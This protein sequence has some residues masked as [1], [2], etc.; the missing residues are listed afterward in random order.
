MIGMRMMELP[1][2]DWRTIR[3][4]LYGY[5]AARQGFPDGTPVTIPVNTDDAREIG[6]LAN[7]LPVEDDDEGIEFRMTDS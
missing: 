2:E 4:A 7:M 5:A 3:D 6:R 1:P